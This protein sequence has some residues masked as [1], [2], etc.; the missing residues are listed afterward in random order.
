M[1]TPVPDFWNIKT[2][3]Q[4]YEEPYYSTIKNWM[5]SVETGIKNNFG[6]NRGLMPSG[7][8]LNTYIGVGYGGAYVASATVVPTL[9]NAPP[10]NPAYSSSTS[11]ENRSVFLVFNGGETG[12]TTQLF[13][14]PG[15]TWYRT[16][17][18]RTYG[19]WVN[20]SAP[21]IAFSK[22]ISG[23]NAASVLKLNEL[24]P[25]NYYTDYARALIENNTPVYKG[26]RLFGTITIHKVSGTRRF[27]IFQSMY[28]VVNNKDQPYTV[29][30]KGM[31]Q[32]P[33]EN[34]GKWRDNWVLLYAS[35]VTPEP[36]PVNNLKVGPSN[37]LRATGAVV[38]MGHSLTVKLNKNMNELRTPASTTKILCSRTL[39]DIL[40]D[41]NNAR[42][43]PLPV[44]TLL[45]QEFTV[46]P[47]DPKSQPTWSGNDIP[48]A[49]GDVL[50]YREAITLF[51]VPSHNQCCEIVARAAGEKISGAGT[52][53]EKFLA[54]M[55]Q[56][57]TDLNFAA[58][59]LFDNPSGASSNC[60][61]TP[62]NLADLAYNTFRF[63]PEIVTEFAK[64]EC[65]VAVRGTNPR[66]LNATMTIRDYGMEN[67]PDWVAGKAGTW[68]EAAFVMM[69][70][71]ESN[72]F[73]G[74][75]AVMGTTATYRFQDL[76][77]AT[78]LVKDNEN[79]AWLV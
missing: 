46:L 14:A 79:K 56:I 31:D 44:N 39:Y 43:T 29:W 32:D 16:A 10:F 19:A 17:P 54:R 7:A 62:S 40:V 35:D 77:T 36:P 49:A 33:N 11:F 42:T 57:C 3:P 55:N 24:P 23:T 73:L 21:E 60:K 61:I 41:E 72:G 53:R 51:A 5:D 9:V 69:W 66:T 71:N 64:T 26:T 74:V 48:L 76:R 70:R 28:G 75:T 59:T 20:L 65:A 68:G 25:G 50:T 22:D 58:G 67:F 2:Q 34:K 15:Q 37:I 1:S 27:M 30:I 18:Y 63:Y 52:P 12:G 4:E 45:D 38:K 78:N 47:T 6:T 13:F 8:D